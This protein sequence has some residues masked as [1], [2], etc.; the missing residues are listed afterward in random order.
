MRE[1][2]ERRKKQEER[3]ARRE[4]QDR[5]D[6]NVID[7]ALAKHVCTLVFTGAKFTKQRYYTCQTCL[8]SGA[9]AQ[10]CAVCEVCK[11][12]CHVNHE[13]TLGGE[14]GFYCDCGAS[15]RCT[16]MERIQSFYTIVKEYEETKIPF[17]DPDFKAGP[18]GCG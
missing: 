12:K 8:S 9:L 18:S 14:E 5:D 10:G 7:A 17:E 3:R 11:D 15:G 6:K 2:E 1:E 13:I 16:A 4:K